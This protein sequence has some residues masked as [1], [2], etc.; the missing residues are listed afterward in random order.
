MPDWKALV[1]ARV[2]ALGVDPPRAADIVDELAQH[3][4][5]HYA[6]L[7]ASGVDDADALRRV[8]APLDDP[9]R[10]AREIAGA[11]RP[12]PAAPAP[13]E[14]GSG[15]ADLGR[16]VRYAARLLL[17]APG[18]AAVAL[19]TLALGIGANTAI[20]SV[21]NAVLLRPLPYSDPDRLVLA[22]E[23]DRD[24]EPGNVGYAT[25]LDWRDRSHGFAAMTL[26]RSWNP[27][28]IANGQA[29]RVSGMRVAAN[30]FRTLGVKPAMGRDFTD[31]DDTPAGLQVVILSDGAWRRTFDADSGVIGRVIAMNG[32]PFTVVGVMPAS[33]EPL[34]SERF[35]T[36]AEMWAPVGYDVS[37]KS[38]CRSCQHLK[39]IARLKPG[40]ALEAARAD[41]DAVQAQLRREHPAD[42]GAQTMTLMPLDDA[43][44]GGIRPALGILMGAVGFV[45]LI[46]C[47]LLLA[48]IARRERD[49]ALRAALGASRARIVRQLMVESGLL[50]LAGGL[51][52]LLVSFVSV[53][54]LVHLAP[55]TMARL[56]G[57]R[58]DGRALAFSMGLSLAT[59]F[60]FGLLPAIKASRVDLQRSLHGEARKT[61]QAATSVARRLL[62]GADVAMAVVLLVGA[63]LMIKSVGRLI[64]VNP[65]FDPDHVLSL[66]ISMIG[67]AYA[68]DGAVVAKIDAILAQLRA[69]PGVES[70]AAAGQIP[71]GGNG[72][73][74][75]FHIE[76]RPIAPDDPAVERYAVT[77]EYFSVMRIPLRRGRLFT[78]ADRGGTENVMLIGEQTARALWAG[79]DPI[80]RH[81][82]IGGDEGPWRTIVGIVGDVRHRDLATAPTMQMYLPQTQNTDQFLT[83]VI[84]AQGDPSR[85][86]AEARRA[87]AAEARDV[88]VFQVAPLTDLV[89]QSVGPRRFV[90]VL[91]ELFGGLALLM[92]AIGVYGVISYSVA[93]RTREI[94]IRAALGAQPRDIVRLVVGGGL[95]VVSLGLA[96]GLVLALAASRFLESSLYNVSTSDPATFA[97]V[98]AVLLLVALI[99]Q[100]VPIVRAMRVDPTVALRQD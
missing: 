51:L 7:T 21:L 2:G 36:R 10:V 84:R 11:D 70:A 5:Q 28:L 13:P 49:L 62:V 33:F 32:L 43:L 80:G 63:G 86:A 34:I 29:E 16:D 57:A 14:A 25:F 40:T 22:G 1:R 85:L 69:L 15:L 91:L 54:L 26:I 47:S 95:T 44:T 93:E 35:Y 74:W 82:K 45:L 6:E 65:G 87:V 76:G 46:A 48:R 27:T 58:M 75:G 100:T 31:A 72:D 52:G 56:A 97:G 60:V 89:A 98:A 12:R 78:D 38:A 4:A 96:A 19:L 24:G 8:L 20:F 18:F 3:V 30:F 67:P 68:K 92:T 88:P 39:A 83:L 53:P 77:P 61:G 99:A 9:E 17:R 94:G 64:G 50:A 23:V 71:L 41:L 37:L 90:M 66:Q 42:Y 79:A 73:T 59:A 55:S 81:V